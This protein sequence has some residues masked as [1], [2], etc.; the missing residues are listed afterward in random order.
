ML[1]R[2]WCYVDDI[3]NKRYGYPKGIDKKIRFFTSIYFALAIGDHAI[4]ISN[5][6]FG[7]L[8]DFKGNYTA[9]MYYNR[10]FR[11]LFRYVEFSTPLG[12]YTSLIT[13]QANLTWAFNDMFIILL[14]ILLASRFKQISDKL[15]KEYQQPNT[16]YYWREIRQ[17]YNKLC[18]LCVDL[19]DTISMIVMTS[20]FQ[21]LTF[22][23]IQLYYSFSNVSK[24]HLRLFRIKEKW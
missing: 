18:E 9:G 24:R 17:D 22:I 1:I 3:F 15:A 2:K 7:L 10:T 14:S 5:R 13:T 6:Y 23:L 20:Y 8:Q 11:D 21:N 4:G 19:N 12:I 16:L